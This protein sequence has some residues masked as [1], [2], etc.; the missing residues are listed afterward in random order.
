MTPLIEGQVL[1]SDHTALGSLEPIGV[2]QLLS[3]GR[4]RDCPHLL[5]EFCVDDHPS[6]E[7]LPIRPVK[8]SGEGRSM[9]LPR[10]VMVEL[11]D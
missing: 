5:P 3:N 9:P 10:S 7:P 8:Q 4:Q 1:S 2:I 6:G 11:L